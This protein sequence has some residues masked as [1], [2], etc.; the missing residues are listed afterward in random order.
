MSDYIDVTE[1]WIKEAKPK[2]GKI[3]F[4]NTVRSKEGIV[5]SQKNAILEYQNGEDLEIGTWF[6][7][8]IWGDVKM[9]PL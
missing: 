7:N 8:N 9:Q 2:G 3:I 1:K 4:A 6:K 5:Y